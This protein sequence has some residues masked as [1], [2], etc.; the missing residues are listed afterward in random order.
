MVELQP[1]RS[2]EGGFEQEL[3]TPYDFLKDNQSTEAEEN[4]YASRVARLAGKIFVI[5]TCGDAR[6]ANGLPPHRTLHVPSI[7]TSSDLD[8]YKDMAKNEFTQ[9]IAN[10]VHYD[11]I[12]YKPGEKPKKCGGFDAKTETKNNRFG[13]KSTGIERYINRMP[14]DDPVIANIFQSEL[15]ANISDKPV[16]AVIQDHR[17]ALFYP[18]VMFL[19]GGTEIRTSMPIRNFLQD[20]Y[21]PKVIYKDGIPCLD[22]TQLIPAFQELLE[23]NR[24]ESARI[25]TEYEDFVKETEFQ[26]PEFLIFTTEK[27][28]ARER[29]P[30][31]LK[32]PSSYFSIHLARENTPT[33]LAVITRGAMQ[34]AIEQAEY[35][36]SH[37]KKI[38]T[39][40]IETPDIEQSKG[41]AKELLRAMKNE[42]WTA[43]CNFQIFSAASISGRTTRIEMVK[44]I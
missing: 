13:K 7:A 35:P 22:E 40:L 27:T 39:I 19:N 15:L 42:N 38:H 30:K 12:T 37:F 14:S 23:L 21:D 3:P 25:Q 1:E 34:E 8:P 2:R 36:I 6:A 44:K 20:L 5:R 11:R 4:R 10:V 26:N 43:V 31:N 28:T 32:K 41:F 16:L 29:Y 9:G 24:I 18:M 17:T 33:K